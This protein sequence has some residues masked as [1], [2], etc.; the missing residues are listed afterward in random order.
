MSF[1]RLV[2]AS[3]IYAA[4]LLHSS[5]AAAQFT[6]ETSIP[7]VL[8]SDST[9]FEPPPVLDGSAHYAPEAGPPAGPPAGPA[10][11]SDRNVFWV[12]GLAGD[13]TA[14]GP[15]STAV[16]NT[17]H[18]YP[19]LEE[20]IVFQDFANFDIMTSAAEKEFSTPAEQRSKNRSGDPNET[21]FVGHSMGGILGRYMPRRHDRLGRP[22]AEFPF[23][24]L[25]T[26]ATPHAGSRLA[27]SAVEFTDLIARGCTAIAEGPAQDEVARRAL[28]RW[29]VSYDKV[30]DFVSGGCVDVAASPLIQALA[31]ER[32][33]PAV[34]VEIAPNSDFLLD[35][36]DSREP[37]AMPKA[38]LTTMEEAP[39]TLKMLSSAQANVQ[40][41]PA[42]GADDDTGLEEDFEENATRYETLARDWQRLADHVGSWWH[43]AWEWEEDGSLDLDEDG[44]RPPNNSKADRF[45]GVSRAYQRGVDFFNEFDNEWRAILG[46]RVFEET[47]RV[48]HCDCTYY[49]YGI[50]AGGWSGETDT[51]EECED[52]D[53]IDEQCLATLLE[54]LGD[55][56]EF[57]T[58]GATLLSSQE[59]WL[60]DDGT[61][62]PTWRSTR[63]NHLQIR[64]SSE[65]QVAVEQR[66][67]GGLIVDWFETPERE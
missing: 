5:T 8:L 52:T 50:P 48:Y 15:V 7:T 13:I 10:T 11:P 54:R 43:G 14:W 58:D 45:R 47:G 53:D 41:L 2:F 36:N 37:Y 3:A 49:D 35:L 12:H 56:H 34:S 31:I 23:H 28:L 64:N 38:N 51:A 26:V 27:E 39:V 67:L 21:M 61:P 24:G 6:V 18:T 9:I 25:V 66:L 22:E 19:L 29:F 46:A 55:W 33:L 57:P 40:S 4:A 17:F 59:S 1:I 32:F 30:S 44:I 65:T 42:Y 60:D 62:V 16:E 20:Y 63:S